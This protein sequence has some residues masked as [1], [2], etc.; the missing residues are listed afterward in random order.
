MTASALSARILNRTRLTDGFLKVDRCEFET[1]M[2]RGGTQRVTREIMHRGHAVGVLAYDPQ[3]DEVVLI[4]EF[5]PGCLIAGDPPFTDNLVAG[6]IDDAESPIAAALREMEEETGLVLREPIVVHPGA[7]VSSGGTSE[8]IAVVF[9]LVDA[10]DAGGVHGNPH[11]AEDILTVAMTA[12]RFIERV[13][14][15]DIT[16]LKT[17]LAGYWFA[18]HRERLRSRR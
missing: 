17:L 16:D 6:A 10:A 18:E 4:N 9:G 7:F 13:R 15:G 8:K 5:R 3:R 1:S 12:E 2:H 11:E 14:S